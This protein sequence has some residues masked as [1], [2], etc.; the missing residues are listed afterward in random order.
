MSQPSS[1]SS[2]PV[3][4]LDLKRQYAP[5][6][7]E[8]EQAL[9]DV[10]RGGTYIL[11]PNVTALEEALASRLNCQHAIGVANGSDAIYLALRAL[12]V[13]A[14]DEVITTA[15]SYIATSESIARAGATPVFV[16]IDE[17]TFNLD[18]E[19]VAA[20]ITPKTRAVL[21]VHL[22]GQP[23]DMTQ[24]MALA[25]AHHLF[26]VEDCAQAIGAAWQGQ[27]VGSFG[28]VGCFSFFPTKNLGAAGDGGLVTTQSSTLNDTLRQLRVHGAKTRYDH[29]S[30]GI[31]S[32]L[33]ELQAALLRVKLPH[34]EAYTKGR[35]QVAQWYREAL[36]DQPEIRLPQVLAGAE[37]VYHQFTVRVPAAKRDTLKERLA[38]ACITT[39]IYYP[40]PLHRQGM[41]K[42]LGY[43]LGSLPVAEKIA[44]EVL[45]LPMFPE[46]TQAEVGRV[47]DGLRRCLAL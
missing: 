46:L 37:H 18:L 2:P 3:P 31:N 8:L 29:V 12:G 20:A 42:A 13:G 30:E 5:L 32:R 10:L 47:V 9:L 27:S 36:A 45:S 1:L 40:I 26:V 14:G 15:M 16:D 7:E 39:M 41:H 38:Q 33:D 28:D 22:F 35:Q 23:V 11:G 44:G 4:I 6:Q 21:P 43:G 17:M 19:K 34:L 25:K 24:L